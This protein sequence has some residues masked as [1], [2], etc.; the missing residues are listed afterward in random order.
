[1]N[2]FILSKFV[3]PLI[4][5]CSDSNFWRLYKGMLNQHIH[6]NLE[7]ADESPARLNNLFHSLFTIP[8]WQPILASSNIKPDIIDNKNAFQ[9]LALLPITFKS[10]YNKNF[11][12]RI[13][14]A[15]H[16]SSWQFLSSAG[17]N[18]RMTVV[19]DFVKRDFLRASEHLTIKLSQGQPFGRRTVDIPPSACNVVCGLADDGPE[20]LFKYLFWLIKNK[21]SFNSAA[22]SDLRGRVERQIFLKRKTLLPIESNDWAHTCIQLDKYLEQITLEKINVIRGYPH[23]LYWLA[24][25]AA[26]KNMRFPHVDV[27][28]PYGGLAGESLVTYICSVFDADFV[29]AYGTGEVGSIGISAK[30]THEIDVYQSVVHVEI[31][32]EQG[33]PVPKGQHRQYS[34]D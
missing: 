12:D 25:R 14:S 28:I 5:L 9:Y 23:F 8:Y 11:P 2:N 16:K 34:R 26:Q 30:N 21:R 15:R 10:T 33:H 3:A 7:S 17:T 22:I 4:E 20:P 6:P 1:M 13:T 27:L 32:D 29:N 31:I 19:T 18:D 24:K